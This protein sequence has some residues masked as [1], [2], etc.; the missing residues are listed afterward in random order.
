[1]S[2]NLAEISPRSAAVCIAISAMTAPDT[3]AEELYQSA[4]THPG[5]AE[6]P[7]E[8][9]RI[10]LAQGMWLRRMRR[11]TDARAALK[12]AADMPALAA[13][14]GCDAD[15]LASTLAAVAPGAPDALGRSFKR[16]LSAPYYAVKVTGT[17]FHTQGGLD[18]DAHCRV[19]RADG[20]KVSVFRQQSDSSGRWNDVA[21]GPEVAVEFENAVLSQ[22]REL[23]LRAVAKN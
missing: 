5:I 9:A 7:F 3:D 2:L 8:Y 15:T 23:R 10:A 4:L 21:V 17:L 22:A 11:H 18:I 16:A 1:M 20:L 6:F 13:L 12:V 14:I 19:L